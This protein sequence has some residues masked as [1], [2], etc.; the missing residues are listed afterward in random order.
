M[1]WNIAFGVYLMG[2]GGFLAV[3]GFLTMVRELR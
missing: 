2:A 3:L 1:N